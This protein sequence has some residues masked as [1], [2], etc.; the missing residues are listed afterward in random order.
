MLLINYLKKP[1]ETTKS[2]MLVLSL[3]HKPRLLG[4]PDLRTSLS[5][6]PSIFQNGPLRKDAI[7][8]IV[9]HIEFRDAH[10]NEQ[11]HVWLANQ[12]E[13]SCMVVRVLQA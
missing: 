12:S 13:D 8:Y 7:C 2:Q 3:E 9:L 1:Q 10:S 4:T 11:A 6:S 5:F